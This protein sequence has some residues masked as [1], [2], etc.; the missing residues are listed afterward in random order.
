MYILTFVRMYVGVYAAT[1]A[2]SQVMQSTMCAVY[3]S[4]AHIKRVLKLTNA[5]L[6]LGCFQTKLYS[7]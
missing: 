4:E 7:G 5:D 1:A 2:P 6:H 3:L